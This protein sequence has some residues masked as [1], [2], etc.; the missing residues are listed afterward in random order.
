MDVDPSIEDLINDY[1]IEFAIYQNI[2][3]FIKRRGYT[4]KLGLL[5]KDIESEKYI[6]DKYELLKLLQINKF[7]T[8]TCIENIYIILINKNNELTDAL[9]NSIKKFPLT[10]KLILIINDIPQQSKE[11][12]TSSIKNKI[13]FI[14]YHFLQNDWLSN[15]GMPTKISIMSEDEIKGLE[16]ANI[17]IKS[18]PKLLASQKICVWLG[19]K[20]GDVIKA[21]DINETSHFTYYEVVH[22]EITKL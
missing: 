14:P 22:R 17:T 3:K 16:F 5:T 11:K 8:V 6:T 10:V 12:I 21:V 4:K 7:I 1:S 9:I 18:L 13:E 20:V 15:I 2:E 19:A